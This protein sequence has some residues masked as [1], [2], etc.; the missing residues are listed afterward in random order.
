MSVLLKMI[1]LLMVAGMTYAAA[2]VG[3]AVGFFAGGQMAEKY[4]VDFDTIDQSK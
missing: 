3:V 4:Y 1:K 2:A